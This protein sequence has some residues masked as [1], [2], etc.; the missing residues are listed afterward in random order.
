MR[1]EQHR[2]GKGAFQIILA[3]LLTWALVFA[4]MPIT[5]LDHVGPDH[6]HSDARDHAVTHEHTHDHEHNHREEGTV[7]ETEAIAYF[8]GDL[9]ERPMHQHLSMQ[10]H[11]PAILP[12][13]GFSA[14]V[15]E[16]TAA[17]PLSPD[18]RRWT[19]ALVE[20]LRPPWRLDQ[21]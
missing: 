13:V 3:C 6:G 20:T 9:S 15:W 18:S 1:I 16:R 12:F 19:D 11:T 8:A 7:S 14:L 17:W 21:H 2:T 4:A 5:H 10:E